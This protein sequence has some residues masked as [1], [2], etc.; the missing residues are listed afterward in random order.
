MQP[1]L[2]C[3]QSDPHKDALPGRKLQIFGDCRQ[4]LGQL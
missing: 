3:R 1:L 4:W 2:Q